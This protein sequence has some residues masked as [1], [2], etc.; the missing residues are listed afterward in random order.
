MKTSA[1]LNVLRNIHTRFQKPTSFAL[2]FL[3]LITPF[4]QVFAQEA[5]AADPAPV[6][7]PAPIPAVDP[8]PSD[9]I[10]PA[11]AVDTVT[12]II[13]PAPLP[14]VED[15]IVAPPLDNTKP[16]ETTP[17][18]STMSMSSNPSD[19]YGPVAVGIG[20]GVRHH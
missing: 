11:S 9:I 1:Q 15:L 12:S 18:P 20:I 4:A 3:F 5:P 17:P 7:D 13:D 16:K 8:T 14:V 2:V 19:I 6:S 10:A